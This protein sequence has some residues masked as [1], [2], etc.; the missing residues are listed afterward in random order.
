M[1]LRFLGKCGPVG[2]LL[3]CGCSFGMFQTAHTQAPGS[4][5]VTPG[6]AQVFNRIDDQAGRSSITN[7]GAQ[8]GGRVGLGK[9]VDVGLGSFFGYGAKVDVKVNL[10]DPRQRL[11]LAPRL[12]A[13]YR[14]QR[15][16]GM[17]E[18]GAITSYRIADQF[19]PYL[20]LTYANHWIEPE[21]PSGPPVPNLAPRRGTGDGL[22]QLN[23]G[24]EL[25]LSEY[26]ALLGEYGHW[27]PLNNDAG[28]F[29]AFIPTNVA[30]LAL[31]IGRVRP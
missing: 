8:L 13:G 22:L 4:V 28:D 9:R 7:L 26:V 25:R 15:N 20:G 30:G 18:G 2:A 14:W 17:L 11:A 27:F 10:L 23:L 24:V 29:Y 3:T 5:S 6:V 12:G 1:K 16:V 31:R 21:P 19:E